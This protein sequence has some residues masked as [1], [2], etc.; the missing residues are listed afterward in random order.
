MKKVASTC[1][2]LIAILAGFHLSAQEN[3]ITPDHV[4]HQNIRTVKLN[5][6]GDPVSLPL[7]TLNSGEKLELNFDDLQYEVKSYY[8]T[9]VLCNAD[10]T[11][12]RMNAIEYL[13]GF[14]E[15]QIQ[16][17]R[18]SSV[19]LQKYVH[20]RVEIPNKNC[21]PVKSGNYLLKVYLDSDTNK[22]AFTRRM[23]VIDNKASVGGFVSQPINPKVF[24]TSQK[25][26]VSINTKGLN[27][28]N[29][30]DQLK[31]VIQQNFRWDNAI[32]GIK[33][34]F[35]KGDVL[36][37]NAEQNI[38]FPGMKEWRWIDLRSFRL[39]TERVEKTDYQR[40]GT[41]VFAMP[42]FPRDNQVYQYIKDIN[43][44]YFPATIDDY[45][46]NF[47]GDYARVNF[48][49][50]AKEPYAGY[51]LYIFGELTDYECNT[52]NKLVYNGARRAYEGALFLKQGFYNYVYGLIDR[53]TNQFSTEYTEGD[54]WET[55]NV[56]TVLVYYRALGGR[57]DELIGQLNLNSIQNR[58]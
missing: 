9:L 54:S 25:V 29:P 5:R 14:S 7:I 2:T 51:D 34:Q 12:V 31:V 24:R 28:P 45:N 17:Y 3:K 18:F 15:N 16:D 56:Y 8:Y 50:P 35:I 13:R 49:F 6:T 33:P 4:Y 42:D 30:F 40:T 46:P 44:R 27:L 37:Y 53:T 36:E 19:A 11:P 41:T 52:A 55:E 20:Y 48:V 39:Q 47:E 23:M 10:W 26:N 22:L 21:T 57:Y 1:F 58:R 43:G 38:I 32:T